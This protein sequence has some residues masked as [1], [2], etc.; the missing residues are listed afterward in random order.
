[1]FFLTAGFFAQCIAPKGLIWIGQPATG[2]FSGQNYCGST[3]A[4]APACSPTP[5]APDEDACTSNRSLNSRAWRTCDYTHDLA[6]VGPISWPR[7][8][9]RP[10]VFNGPVW[11]QLTRWKHKVAAGADWTHKLAASTRS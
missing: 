8:V 6:A 5:C 3:I 10:F 7:G 11:E 1:M 4:T 9:R 2:A